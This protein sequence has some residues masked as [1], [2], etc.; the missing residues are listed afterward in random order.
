LE[1]LDYKHITQPFTVRIH[2]DFMHFMTRFSFVVFRRYVII[3]FCGI[4]LTAAT[5][6]FAFAQGILPNGTRVVTV[7]PN[8]EGIS[9]A[10]FLQSGTNTRVA[11]LA[12][13]RTGANRRL[14]LVRE[15]ENS[16]MPENIEVSANASLLN[17]ADMTARG[18]ALAIVYAVP[19][20]NNTN[21]TFFTTLDD[22]TS[23]LAPVQTVLGGAN[24]LQNQ[25]V[26]ISSTATTYIMGLLQGA[27]ALKGYALQGT[28]WQERISGSFTQQLS[29][30]ANLRDAVPPLLFVPNRSLSGFDAFLRQTNSLSQT[31]TPASLFPLPFPATSAVSV[32]IRTPIFDSAEFLYDAV[33][34]RDSLCLLAG[35]VLDRTNVLRQV[36]LY[37]VQTDASGV[38]RVFN[39]QSVF[40]NSPTD[41]VRSAVLAFDSRGI[42]TVAMATNSRLII[43]QRTSTV[44]GGQ[45]ITVYEQSGLQ[46]P[47]DVARPLALTFTNVGSASGAT[48]N[49]QLQLLYQSRDTVYMF[50]TPSCFTR[51]E[52][53]LM[54]TS[55]T[56]SDRTDRM[57]LPSYNDGSS[58]GW[59]LSP[60][61]TGVPDGTFT[62]ITFSQFSTEPASMTKAGDVV[63]VYDGAD[64]NAALLGRFS[65]S[66][67][68]DFT[69]RSCSP[70][71][72]VRF[73]SDNTIAR[74]GWT[75]RYRLVL[76][77]SPDI[78]FL[79][80][81][82]PQQF[83]LTNALCNRSIGRVVQG[84]AGGQVRI[85]LSGLQLS[86]QDTVRVFEGTSAA[87]M[88]RGQFLATAPAPAPILSMS[89]TLFV[90][91]LRGRT[92][93]AALQPASMQPPAL[94][95]PDAS[96][97]ITAQLEMP[98]M[99]QMPVTTPTV[100]LPTVTVPPRILAEPSA[101]NMGTVQR[102]IQSML[103]TV[104]SPINLGA[105][106]I[107]I[108]SASPLVTISL[109]EN[110]GFSSAQLVNAR[111]PQIPL[112][113]R[114][115]SPNAG[116]FVERVNLTFTSQSGVITTTVTVSAIVPGQNWSV[117]P[118]RIDTT[119]YGSVRLVSVPVN[120]SRTAQNLEGRVIRATAAD[121]TRGVFRFRNG[122][123]ESTVRG[124]SVLLSLEFAP[125]AADRPRGTQCYSGLLRLV[126]QIATSGTGQVV[127]EEF[128]VPVIGCGVDATLQLVTRLRF[129]LEDSQGKILNAE[130]G[131]QIRI[132]PRQ[133][134]R[135]RIL[136]DSVLNPQGLDLRSFSGTIS[137]GRADMLTVPTQ[138]ATILHPRLPEF[139]QQV[140][141]PPSTSG[142]VIGVRFQNLELSQ[143]AR[144]SL[145]RGLSP[146][147]IALLGIQTQL[148]GLLGK[149]QIGYPG[150]VAG[151]L[152]WDFDTTRVPRS[153]E[154]VL[155]DSLKV[156]VDPECKDAQGNDI[157]IVRRNALP[158]AGRMVALAP[159]PINAGFGEITYT[160]QTSE[161]VEVHILNTLGDRVKTILQGIQHERG[162]YSIP[163]E[164]SSLASGTYIVVVQ[165]A[166]SGTFHAM[167][168][169]VR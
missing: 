169:V 95:R 156:L 119:A 61:P 31:L 56:F 3:F 90:Q 18:N 153:R 140:S 55:Q 103:R 97:I 146:V 114:F 123:S 39:V 82:A 78:P 108:Q 87:G 4:L 154:I 139:S 125:P 110:Q 1:C 33:N 32:V 12:A 167:V 36:L 22:G 13:T 141:F 83:T 161:Q 81:A 62:E 8:L 157:F 2:P 158:N 92:P 88:L 9:K 44:P 152:E 10:I 25:R 120:L 59:L 57:N 77:P 7:I 43:R 142:G 28:A 137:F 21:T 124:D 150:R 49:Q 127:S 85:S 96:V 104:I 155:D 98:Q 41:P 113:V 27:S 34:T 147:T 54:T 94:N 67:Q 35:N 144:D 58:C 121:D 60:P 134:L 143:S 163:F 165:A 46:I 19:G 26:M 99:M 14:V 138:R 162:V 69:V 164:T 145:R 111:S 66:F 52:L 151:R 71:V 118:I 132:P 17:N 89:N 122:F 109:F 101:L 128:T 5:P 116:V 23:T 29:D 117:Q 15:R 38:S 133:D 48:G 20:A 159:N 105:G 53:P 63:S 64:T 68:Q 84:A 112:F 148:S 107:T 91:L 11:F 115:T 106:N 50:R 40:D 16:S 149:A 86:E 24:N 93:P 135:L 47:N 166:L 79:A 73:T 51:T 131:T 6:Y 72:F 102:N 30:G 76:P 136:V 160:V 74:E 37:N 75:A 42:P 130:R 65:G 80:T 70:Q 100:T 129:R 126:A 168:Q 45:W